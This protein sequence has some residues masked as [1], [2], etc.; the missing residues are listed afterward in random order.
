M[1]Q[2]FLLLFALAFSLLVSAQSFEGIITTSANQPS[3]DTEILLTKESAK[4]SA[5]TD[6][7]GKFIILLKEDGNYKLEII[8]DGIVTTTEN[9]TVKG[10]LLKNFEIKE[11]AAP[12]E[13]K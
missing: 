8:K 5:I 12:A 13:Q 1:T 3:G 11:E 2:K 9:I 10:N 7:K 6:E 4:F